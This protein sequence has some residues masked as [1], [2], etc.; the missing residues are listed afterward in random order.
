MTNPA[1]RECA[2]KPVASRPALVT[3]WVI[4][5]ER[6]SG[7]RPRLLTRLPLETER[8]TRPSVMP[9]AVSQLRSPVTGR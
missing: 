6:P 1:R 9:A 8:K 3:A 2:E 5:R 7:V 4:R